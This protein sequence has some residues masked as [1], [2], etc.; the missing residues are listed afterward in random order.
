MSLPASPAPSGVRLS[1][2]QTIKGTKTFQSSADSV[3]NLLNKGRVDVQN[4]TS[5]LPTYGS[6]I[7]DS[8][9]WTSTNWTGSFGGGYTHTVGNTSAL[10]RAVTGS[11][12][13]KVY[14]VSWTCSGRTA[15]TYTVSV[16][17]ITLGGSSLSTNT[18]V[19]HGV[20]CNASA[21]IVFTPSSDFDGTISN[22]SVQEITAGVAAPQR[23]LAQDGTSRVE[24]RPAAT[25]SN[26]FIGLT[27]GRYSFTGASNVGLG[28]TALQNLLSGASNTA[29]G[30]A[31]LA[32]LQ[33][34]SNNTGIGAAALQAVT[35]GAGNTALGASCLG[36]ITT[37]NSNTAIGTLCL[38]SNTTGSNNVG[39]GVST[40]AAAGTYSSCTAVGAVAL[41]SC[42]GSSNTGVGLRAGTGISGS[43]TACTSGTFNT[44]L[45]QET[46]FQ[47]STQR[48]YAICIGYRAQADAD[49]ACIIGGTSTLAVNVGIGGV[50]AP[51]AR[52]DVLG[53]GT[54]TGLGL[55]IMNSSSTPNF[56]VRDDG[57]FAFRGGTVGVAQTGYAVTNPVT[58]RS[59]DTTTITLPQLAEVVGTMIADDITKGLRAA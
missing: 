16:S 10:S 17:N 41:S 12:S 25:A 44:F 37:G 21:N 14:K 59:F 28:V 39:I 38:N 51:G 29:I 24:V 7:M 5:D 50:Q 23:F 56:T 11:S 33:S 31:A 55:R 46:G 43:T 9:G 30:A 53:Q 48:N 36:A 13:G 27:T 32:A 8:S 42:T 57:G 2:V 58:R 35:N 6:E 26:V 22:I 20:V 4:L 18:T 19:T 1:G 40:L 34:G 52:L 45:G 3:T 47:T 54:T 15:G 49:N